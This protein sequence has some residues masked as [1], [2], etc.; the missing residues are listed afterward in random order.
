LKKI[1]FIDLYAGIGG[2]RLGFQNAFSAQ[3]KFVFSNEIDN[4]AC[5]TY[6]ANFGENP[7]GDITKTKSSEIPDFDILLAGFPCQAFSIAGRRKGFGD[8]RGTHFFEIARV[9]KDKKPAAFF[10]ENVK[11]FMS[12]DDGR[13][14][15]TIKKVIEEDLGYTFYHKV[16]NAKDFGRPQNRE[17]IYMVGFKDPIKFEFPSATH[18]KVAVRDILERNVGDEFF[19]SQRYL[20]TL[21]KHRT[22]HE[23]KGNGFGFM[24]LK[25]TDIANTIVLGGMGRERNLIVDQESF[26]KSK[27]TNINSEAVRSLTP[28]EFLRL[29]G[30]PD[31]F[32]IVAPKSQMYR[33]TANSVAVPV[34]DAI[35]RSMKKA[36]A[37]SKNLDI[38]PIH[39]G[40]CG[41]KLLKGLNDPHIQTCGNLAL[42]SVCFNKHDKFR[43]ILGQ[44]V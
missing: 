18:D 28:R 15:K 13:T 20:N 27:R 17:R 21:K 6:E 36:L 10:L 22:R 30:F 3:A 43:K 23:E 38:K 14:F 35:A 44:H 11:H 41:K 39:C 37:E 2:I 32:K 24:I 12:H 1:R 9:I 29:Q 19:L 42:W 16:L 5:K 34:V 25:K 33:Q 40:I 31:S 26:K 4:S 8:I 7:K